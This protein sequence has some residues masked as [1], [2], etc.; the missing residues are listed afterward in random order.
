MTELLRRIYAEDRSLWSNF[1]V[2]VDLQDGCWSNGVPRLYVRDHALLGWF[3]FI[4]QARP[5]SSA[6]TD[7]N[8]KWKGHIMG[9]SQPCGSSWV[10]DIW[11]PSAFAHMHLEIA[12]KCTCF[13]GTTQLS[14]HG[15]R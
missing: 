3:S 1:R 14:H 2:V 12:C 4:Q 8:L 7:I 6:L 11:K 5:E 9:D 10:P 13:V 15:C